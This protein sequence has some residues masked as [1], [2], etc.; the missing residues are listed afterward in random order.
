[1]TFNNELKDLDLVIKGKKQA[2]SYFK[3]Q[4]QEIEAQSADSGE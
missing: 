4:A 1:M 3:L 2:I